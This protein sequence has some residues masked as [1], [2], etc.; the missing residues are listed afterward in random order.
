[1]LTAF[2]VEDEL[3]HSRTQFNTVLPDTLGI[4]KLNTYML[5]DTNVIAFANIEML[6][7][8]CSM[9]KPHMGGGAVGVYKMILKNKKKEFL[10]I[11]KP[12]KELEDLAIPEK[13]YDDVDEQE[14]LN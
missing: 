10:N 9:K 7:K 4:K 11:C 14:R 6:G 3:L 2:I 13:Y 8:K 5:T 12:I 1:M